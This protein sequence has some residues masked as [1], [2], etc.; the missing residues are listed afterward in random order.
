MK[1][2]SLL[3][4]FGF[5]LGAVASEISPDQTAQVDESSAPVP[6][7]ETTT[8]EGQPSQTARGRRR[9]RR[10]NNS[11]SDDDTNDPESDE[12]DL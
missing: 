4:L 3:A 5:F 10:E 11:D 7:E 12:S 6:V 1:I 2:Y 8:Q 9:N